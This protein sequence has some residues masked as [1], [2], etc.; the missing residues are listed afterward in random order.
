MFI[1]QVTTR[2]AQ[3]KRKNAMEEPQGIGAPSGGEH[4]RKIA[5]KLR[6]IARECRFPGAR[7]EILDLASRLERRADDLDS[8]SGSAG[9]GQTTH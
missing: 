9:S 6:E 3:A 8:R 2:N 4:Y 1:T 7:R 5:S